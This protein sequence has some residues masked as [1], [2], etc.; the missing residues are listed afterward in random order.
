MQVLIGHTAPLRS[1]DRR[2]AGF[3]AEVYQ[4]CMRHERGK[5]KE[6]TGGKTKHAQSGDRR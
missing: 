1:S 3:V 2:G 6:L 5:R 4:I